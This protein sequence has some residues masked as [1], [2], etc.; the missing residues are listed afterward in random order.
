M[1]SVQFGSVVILKQSRAKK[2]VMDKLFGDK[3]HTQKLLHRERAGVNE[4]FEK[5]VAENYGGE[6]TLVLYPRVNQRVVMTGQD[7]EAARQLLANNDELARQLYVKKEGD[8]EPATF[9]TE[10]VS[11]ETVEFNAADFMAYQASVAIDLTP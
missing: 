11:P 2:K 5:Y 4:R 10:F 9:N 7:A 6:D 8:V 3:H 1:T